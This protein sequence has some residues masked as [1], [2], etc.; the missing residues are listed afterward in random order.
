MLHGHIELTGGGP[1]EVQH[2]AAGNPWLRAQADQLVGRIEPPRVAKHD[3]G[4]AVRAGATHAPSIERHAA[5]SRRL[6]LLA[7]KRKHQHQVFQS[8]VLELSDQHTD[9]GQ[10]AA[11]V[12]PAEQH[13]CLPVRFIPVPGGFALVV[14]I[15]G[16]VGVGIAE[17]ADN[18]LGRALEHL[19]QRRVKAALFEQSAPVF[20]GKNQLFSRR[21][22]GPGS[23]CQRWMHSC[24]SSCDEKGRDCISGS[25]RLPAQASRAAGC[26]GV[27]VLAGCGLGTAS[28]CRHNGVLNGYR[29]KRRVLSV[30]DLPA[31]DRVRIVLV[32]TS[33]AANIGAAA[34]AMK[35]MGLSRLVLV[36][37]GQDPMDDASI[38][39]ASGAEDLV[40]GAVIESSLDAALAGCTRVIGTS[41][42]SR[43]LPWPM[44]APHELGPCLA[45]V[46][47][48]SPVALVFGRERSGLTNEELAR[49]HYHLQIPANPEFSSLNI[50]AAVQVVCYELRRAM[51][52]DADGAS[53]FEPVERASSEQL[54]GFFGHL[55]EMLVDIGFADPN[56]QRQLMLKL[57]RFFLRAQPEPTELNILRGIVSQAQ[58]QT[59]R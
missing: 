23:E 17:R 53:A 57:R 36:N 27:C 30:T 2:G 26:Q 59:R 35:T 15:D 56:N 41:A 25:E 22:C 7:N 33:L 42:R 39:R 13:I 54:E 6:S 10:T 51:M 18:T 16:L 47:A 5:S 14:K 12:V 29:T 1:H 4:Q 50:A 45:E 49:C 8:A 52:A 3:T 11:E 34:R 21:L 46:P 55:E 40:S 28:N 20:T 19:I 32:E 9:I 37:P 31:L 38:A 48:T 58:K 24:L 44:L 43:T